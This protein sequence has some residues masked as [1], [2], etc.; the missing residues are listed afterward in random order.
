MRLSRRDFYQAKLAELNSQM[1]DVA[2]SQTRALYKAAL[3]LAPDD[4]FLHENFAQFLEQIG[5]LPEAVEEERLAGE[6]MPQTPAVPCKIAMLLVRQGNSLE[7]EESLSNA[8]AIR[9]DYAPALN[10]LGV[11]L[12]NHQN[13]TAAVEYL[14]RAIKANPGYPDAYLNLGFLEHCEGKL[15]QASE[16][17]R[18]AAELQPGGPDAYYY[19]AV[20]HQENEA[21]NDFRAAIWMNPS[22][23]Q[24][25]YWLGM[26]LVKEGQIEE[27]Q[28]QFSQVV[29]IRPDFARAHLMY[30][31]G[32]ARQGK[33]SE[34]LKEIQITLQLGSHELNKRNKTSKSFDRT[35]RRRKPRTNEESSR[36]KT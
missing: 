32:L 25:R 1:N 35:S 4:S 19:Q 13:T 12:A 11:I 28:G 5:D 27:A 7:A 23:W 29:R 16:N 10:E 30:G 20:A 6:L 3:A 21:V 34:A 9:G 36:K 8:L 15:D 14:T 17:Y 26:E 33:L 24:A 31:I 18:Q 22:F 2:R